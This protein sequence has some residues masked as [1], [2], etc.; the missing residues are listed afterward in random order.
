MFKYNH[1]VSIL[2]SKQ[3]TDLFNKYYLLKKI[4]NACC[5]SIDEFETSN[6]FLLISL[7]ILKNDA[8]VMYVL[9]KRMHG[10]IMNSVKIAILAHVSVV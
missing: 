7:I 9:N 10:L 3:N 6:F 5:S 2:L 4:N 1:N 8:N